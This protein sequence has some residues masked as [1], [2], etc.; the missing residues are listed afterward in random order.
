MPR[1]VAYLFLGSVF[2]L[3]ASSLLGSGWIGLFVGYWLGGAGGIVLG[4]A[5]NLMLTSGR[6]TDRAVGGEA[7]AA[8]A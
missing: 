3:V 5:A 7:M 8:Q 4:A 1:L 6:E 2:G